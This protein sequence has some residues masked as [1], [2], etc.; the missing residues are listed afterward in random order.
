[1]GGQ[2]TGLGS[3]ISI[4]LRPWLPVRILII[5]SPHNVRPSRMGFACNSVRKKA[6]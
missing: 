4:A 6:S 1:M 5:L 3:Q 2:G